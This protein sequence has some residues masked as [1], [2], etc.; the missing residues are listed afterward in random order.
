[1]IELMGVTKCFDGGIV[2]L[3]DVSLRVNKGELVLLTG[4]SGAGKSTLLRTIF[5][6]EVPQEGQIVIAGRNICRLRRSSIPYLRRNVGVVFQDFKLLGA[7][8]ALANVAVALEIRGMRKKEV[9]RRSMESL[10]AVGL[11]DFAQRT[12]SRLSGGEQQRVA[13]ARAIVG[14]PAILLADEPT[15]NLDPD[16]SIDI[17]ALLARI[18]TEGTTVVVAT[19]DPLVVAHAASDQIVELDEG[20]VAAS[21]LG[22]GG[23]VGRAA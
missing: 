8:S 9:R 21:R 11:V 20:R 3:R 22:T 4:K 23:A 12:V 13:I 16:R 18:A 5:A 17:L 10:D 1:M 15:G 6:A 2:A 19:H 14:S 7:R